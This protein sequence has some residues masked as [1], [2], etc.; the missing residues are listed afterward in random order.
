[1]LS[2]RAENIMPSATAVV[3]AIVE[4][5]TAQGVP[6]IGLNVGEPDFP[7]PAHVAEACCQAL[8]EGKTKYAQTA[9]LEVL[10]AAV[11]RKLKKDNGLNYTPAQIVMTT[12]AKQ[13]VYEALQALVS[14]G[15]EVIIPTP[16]WVSYT[17]MVKLAGGVPV[18]VKTQPGTFGLDVD[19]VR[20]AVTEK[21][22]AVILNT[23]NNPTGAVYTE[24]ALRELGEL[25]VER[26][27]YVIA[28]E[29]YEKL[30]YNGKKH[31]SIASFSPEIYAHTV[32]INGFS[33][34]YAMTG[35]RLGYLAAP[36]PIAKAAVKIQGHLTSCSTVFVQWAAIAALEGPQE[37]VEM[38]RQEFDR[39]RIWLQAALNEIPGISCAEADGAFYL[40]PKVS[41][42]YGKTAPDGS[43][44]KDSSD[45][46]TYLLKAEH[47]ALVPGN[48]FESPE[49]VRIAYANSMEN[50]QEAAARIKK[51]LAALK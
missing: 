50:I 33:K 34:A 26:D 27:F 28:D 49:E 11:C 31:V 17:E 41:A 9:G 24:E 48:A 51:A 23:P 29:I 2:N 45:L 8:W 10:R 7:T 3:T 1:M 47:V 22:K 39:R 13:A 32:T 46:C 38:M 12:G 25:A 44:I 40:M 4:D 36:L 19:A 37:T 35:W 14:D 21:T 30:V 15:D 6:V 16:C 42:Y 18:F 5:L 43:V 20:A